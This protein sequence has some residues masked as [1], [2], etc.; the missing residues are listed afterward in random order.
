MRHCSPHSSRPDRARGWPSALR[1]AAPTGTTP[2]APAPPD[3]PPQRPPDRRAGHLPRGHLEVLRRHGR[4]GH[5]TAVRQHRRQTWTGRPR[6]LHLPD[7]HRRLPVEHRRRPRH[8]PDQPEA[9]PA[10]GS[11]QTHATRSPSWRSTSRRGMFYNW[12]D[13]A[14][15]DKLTTWPANGRHR[16]PVRLQR[17][18]RLAGDRAAGRRPRRRRRSPTRPTPSAR[19]WTSASTT[20]RTPASRRTAGRPGR[21]PDQRRLLGRAAAGLLAARATTAS[22]HRAGLPHLPPL[23]RVQHRAADGVVPGHRG[24]PDPGQALLRDP[25]APSRRQLRLHAGPRPSRPASGTATTASTSSRARCPTA[26]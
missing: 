2:P 21:R 11:K 19:R 10:P 3:R 6:A 8:R 14:T 4:P 22:R 25:C 16:P 5:R 18:Q 1:S 9:R 26:A 24:R 7:Q 13:P 23:R 15:G 20:T 12:Y 17:R